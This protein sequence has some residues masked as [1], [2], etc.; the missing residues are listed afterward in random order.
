MGTGH[1]DLA[2]LQAIDCTSTGIT[3]GGQNLVTIHYG[4]GPDVVLP[5]LVNFSSFN[6][7]TVG[8]HPGQITQVA[9]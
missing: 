4:N 1:I 3:L 6:I 5:Q 9:I 7:F 2:K 8:T